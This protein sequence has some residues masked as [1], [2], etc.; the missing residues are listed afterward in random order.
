MAWPV[1]AQV[2]FGELSTNAN[3]M[4]STGYTADY[5]NMTSSDHGWTVGGTGNLSG[6]FHNPNFLS[7]NATL[8]LNQSRANSNFQSISNASGGDVSANIFGGSAFPG[9]IGYSK[10]YN[11][12]GNYA[13]PGLANYVTHGNSD[14]FGINWSENL[15]DVPSLSAGLQMGSSQ[16]SVYG[17]NDEG[18]NKFHS[19]NLHSGYRL[20]DFTMSAFYSKGASH[21][22]IPQVVAGEQTTE[23]HSDSNSSGF[24]VTHP[25]PLHGSISAGVNR[26]NWNSDY[27]G[28]SSTGTIDI[29]NAQAAVHPATK[30]SF[31]ASANY[32][33]N[34]TGQLY[35]SVIA[36][37]EVVPGLNSNQSSNSLDLM[38]VASYSPG[39]SVQTS[40]FAERHTQS[41]LGKDYGVNSYGGSAS[42]TH[43][44]L[45]GAFNAAGT[46]TANSSDNTGEDTLGFSTTENYSSVILG[47]HV[48]GSFGYAQNVQT[49]LVT[50]MN[51]Y[52]NYSGNASRNWGRLNLTA[53]AAAA[54]TGLTNQPSTENSSETYNA[55]V[56]YTPYLRAS[57]T[58]SKSSGQA[59]ATG[60]GL[61]PVP[62]PVPS[63]TLPSNLVTLFGGDSYSFALSSNPEKHLI[64]SA[65]YA[66]SI[67]NTSSDTIASSNQN[68]EFNSLVQYQVRKLYFNSGYARLEQGFSASGTHPQIISSFYVGVS[69]WFNFF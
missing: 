46:V 40:A 32:S 52:F 37:G 51:S 28:S 66:K 64:L 7:Y 23:T 16:Y 68:N 57:G 59:L 18:N 10:A 12:E 39:L 45:A 43:R 42:Y 34:L 15:R 24:N 50:Y 6:S 53:G 17:T 47:W 48:N 30:L 55:S 27:M 38:G 67:S 69:R 9:S 62:T 31:T 65:A 35:Q 33:D 41:F 19:F 58:Y 36:A 4:I 20:D 21:S 61:V 1:A 13:V 60:A 14:T 44:L 5:G 8:Y 11:S 29:F 2:Q 26:S 22:L 49:L 3:G 25:L 63:P 56:G 54:R